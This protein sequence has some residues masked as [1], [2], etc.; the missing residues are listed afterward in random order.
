MTILQTA[1]AAHQLGLKLVIIPSGQKG[2]REHG[3]HLK[4]FT[5]DEIQ[6]RLEHEQDSNIGLIQG[7]VS[8]V[9]DLEGDEAT[10][11]A[12]FQKLFEGCDVPET[13]S[14][15]SRRGIHR[16]FQF[17]ERLAEIKKAVVK[18]DGL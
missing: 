15:R 14:W 6:A 2:P 17:D 16:L 5:V 12:D 1:L 8:G 18:I 9:I 10:S 13:P 3:W 11:E 4:R 7:G